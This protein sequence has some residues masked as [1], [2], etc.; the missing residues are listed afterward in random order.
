MSLSL[1]TFCTSAL[2]HSLVET[3][4]LHWKITKT[5][6]FRI[7]E[8]ILIALLT[9]LWNLLVPRR[10]INWFIT[11]NYQECENLECILSSIKCQD[12]HLFESNV[13]IKSEL[14]VGPNPSFCRKRNWASGRW[15]TFNYLQ[16]D[17]WWAI[18]KKTAFW[19]TLFSQG[20][21]FSFLWMIN[22][23]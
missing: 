5:Q 12:L 15:G 10:F 7:R 16:Y 13:R 8:V 22:F 19:S 14:R 17:F 23:I 18:L 3:K 11:L 20:I 4:L 21:D 6:L 9:L 2:T 1:S